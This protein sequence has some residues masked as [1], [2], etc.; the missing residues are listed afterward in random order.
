MVK[1]KEHEKTAY[2]IM[3]KR[4]DSLDVY[5]N[6]FKSRKIVRRRLNDESACTLLCTTP[7]PTILTVD[8]Y[9]HVPR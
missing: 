2:V 6:S 7:L 3:S 5:Q 8:I 4:E 9:L 1:T